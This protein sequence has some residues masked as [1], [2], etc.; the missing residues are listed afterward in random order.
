MRW[1]FFAQLIA[2]RHA[3]KVVSSAQILPFWKDV[4]TSTIPESYVSYLL[5][6]LGWR[7][8]VLP[9]T[10]LR[11]VCW[12][13][14]CCG[15]ARLPDCAQDCR[16]VHL[17]WDGERL[18]LLQCLLFVHTENILPWG[19]IYG[20]DHQIVK[21]NMICNVRAQGSVNL[22]SPPLERSEH[23]IHCPSRQK[24]W[25]GCWMDVPCDCSQASTFSLNWRRLSWDKYTFDFSLHASIFSQDWW[26][27]FLRDWYKIFSWEIYVLRCKMNFRCF[28]HV[29]IFWSGKADCCLPIFPH[30]LCCMWIT[31]FI[32]SRCFETARIFQK[33][34]HINSFFLNI[35]RYSVVFGDEILHS[36]RTLLI[37]THLT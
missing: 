19:L 11:G 34:Q 37:S 27:I 16:A 5:L 30:V 3:L 29:P 25:R 14:A 8:C 10:V 12:C 1:I 33:I 18:Q 15:P 32:L 28:S 7:V 23:S 9:S 35:A 22:W 6:I 2:H 13:R 17:V 31:C 36:Q 26:W 24:W 4:S 20:S 21:W